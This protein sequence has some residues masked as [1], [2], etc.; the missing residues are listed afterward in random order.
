MVVSVALLQELIPP[1]SNWS[2]QFRR[3][4]RRAG[5]MLAAGGLVG[6]VYEHAGLAGILGIDGATYLISRLLLLPHA[7]GAF[8]AP[9]LRGGPV[10]LYRAAV[11]AEAASELVARRPPAASTVAEPEPLSRRAGRKSKKA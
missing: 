6:L 1:A 7:P 9:R 11:L 4:D 3:T 2:A 5:G 10:L 8:P